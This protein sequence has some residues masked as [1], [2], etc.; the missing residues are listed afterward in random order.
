MQAENYG[1]KI[2]N[3]KNPFSEMTLHSLMGFIALHEKDYETATDE[4][5][6]ADTTNAYIMYHLARA[7]EGKGDRDR[8]MHMYKE[9]AEANNMYSIGYA[10]I[11]SKAKKMLAMM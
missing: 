9:A 5:E 2:K 1:A 11:R 4:F 6:Q 7:Y 3:E 10:V 8:A